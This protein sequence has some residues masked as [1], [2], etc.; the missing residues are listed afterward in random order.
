MVFSSLFSKFSACM[1]PPVYERVPGE[2]L[3]ELSAGRVD[4]TTIERV[5]ERTQRIRSKIVDK[6]FV[7]ITKVMECA[8]QMGHSSCKYQIKSKVPGV[9]KV[10]HKRLQELGFNVRRGTECHYCLFEV[11][12]LHISW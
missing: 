8:S 4:L 10:V 1:C 7:E 12:H 5:R 6:E 9:E 2:D 3:L 11:S